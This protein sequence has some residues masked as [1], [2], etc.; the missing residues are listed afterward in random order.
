MSEEKKSLEEV[1]A[2]IQAQNKVQIEDEKNHPE[3][4]VLDNED[5]RFLPDD[6][7]IDPVYAQ[8]ELIMVAD[9]IL[10]RDCCINCEEWDP[11]LCRAGDCPAEIF[12]NN[13]D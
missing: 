9:E 6:E 10:H 1:V 4:E 5:E 7:I 12:T 2:K 3:E 11:V 8:P 13:P